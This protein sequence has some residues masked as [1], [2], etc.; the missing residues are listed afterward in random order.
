ML[1]GNRIYYVRTDGSDS[2][3]GLAD[4]AGGAFLTIQ[5]AIDTVLTIDLGGHAVTIQVGAGTY[6]A[7]VNLST[8]FV[9]GNVTL[10][11]DTTTPSNVVISPSSGNCIAV[12][13]KASL[14]IGGFKLVASAGYGIY[15]AS[16]AVVSIANKMDFGACANNHMG[17]FAAIINVNTDYAISGEAAVHAYAADQGTIND[18]YRTVTLTGTPN[19]STAFAQVE[20]LADVLMFGN[21][22]SGSAT[23]T[24]YS[25]SYNAVL[26]TGGATLPGCCRRDRRRRSVQ[27]AHHPRLHPNNSTE[28]RSW[29]HPAMTRACAGFSCTKAATPIIRPI[30][31]VRPISASPSTTIANT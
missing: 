6:A 17:A 20:R 9:G 22:F 24:R 25:V 29:Q 7:G 27:L 10:V 23:G 15:A 26:F 31:A 14:T 28:T 11:G 1:T 30:P 4:T 19:F 16:N 8:A 12:T 5:K 2:N 21:T 13:N 3:D 18:Y